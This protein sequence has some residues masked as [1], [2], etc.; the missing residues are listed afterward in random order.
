MGETSH[1]LAELAHAMTAEGVI[2]ENCVGSEAGVEALLTRAFDIILIDTSLQEKA[3]L[4]DTLSTM[5]PIPILGIVPQSGR[6]GAWVT[7]DHV[8]ILIALSWDL[9][10]LAAIACA[11]AKRISIRAA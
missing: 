8:A 6:K 5:G 7:G 2:C 4:S 10:E 3:G 9:E 11:A 1:A